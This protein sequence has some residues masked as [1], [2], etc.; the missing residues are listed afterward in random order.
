MNV[1]TQRLK[2]LRKGMKQAGLGAYIIPTDDYHGSEYVC[3]HFRA[4]EYF[5]G[6]TGSAGTLVVLPEKAYLWTDGRYFLQAAKQLEGSGIE[7]MRLGEKDV[8][9]IGDFLHDTLEENAAL[10]FDGATMDARTVKSYSALFADK[11]IEIRSGEDLIS[12]IWTDRPP[13]PEA[14]AW[15]LDEKYAG[16][17]AEHKLK[18]IRAAMEE[19]GAELWVL[20]DCEDIA[21][22]LNI[23]GGDMPHTPVPLC[24]CFVE[25][26]RVT[27]CI[28]AK[29]RSDEFDAALEAL[30][31]EFRPYEAALG[32]AARYEKGTMAML[33]AAK[34]NYSLWSALNQN[35]IVV[36]AGDQ[37]TR[38][39]I[40]KNETQIRHMR[41]AHRKD[42]A[43]L[44]KFMRWI[45]KNA[46]REGVSELSAAEYLD[47][48]RL[49][50]EGCIGLSFETICGYGEHAAIVHYKADAQS[51]VP[52]EARGLL[53]VDS[54][55]QYYEGT[56]DLT[57]TYALGAVTEKEKRHYTLVLKAMLALMNARFPADT[58]GEQLD[59]LAR[60]PI[61]REGLDYRHG[62]GHGVGYLLGVHEDP[63]RIRHKHEGFIFAPGMVVS[64]EPGIYEEESHGIRLENLLLCRKAETT[65]YGEFLCFEPLTLSP[66]D[67]D[68]VEDSMLN[69]EEKSAL[70]AYH[71][72]VLSA[73]TPCFEGESEMLE[74]LK[75]A[76]RAI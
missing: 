62:T 27:L 10:G 66:I 75:E 69:A 18:A 12:P 46:G 42:G 43:V 74:W 16:E 24:F 67:L 68:A 3:A 57:R 76:T 35:A 73:L 2:A 5:S 52:I 28:D 71:A 63:V 38:G 29:K 37:L 31:V 21:W 15:L 17:S 9:E 70:N 61:W 59:M 53:L 20:S 39:R 19:Q 60:A 47:E 7:L 65:P 1:I 48:M 26:E 72:Q 45:K 40:I 50:T 25:K 22:L 6:F 32:C 8:P 44:A 23:R 13:M 11:E 64:D 4:R 30:G 55:G 36:E 56:T 51:N 41:E 34:T 49:K 58:E 33:S 14:K 54:G